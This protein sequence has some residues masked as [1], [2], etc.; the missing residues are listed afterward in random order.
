MDS[1]TASQKVKDQ[2]QAIVTTLA[3]ELTVLLKTPIDEIRSRF[4]ARLA[5]GIEKVRRGDIVIVPGYDNLYGTVK[6]WSDDEETPDDSS[7][8]SL[9]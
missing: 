6:I 9:L 7:Q 4:G 3:D 8:M 1:T 2:Y 5:Q